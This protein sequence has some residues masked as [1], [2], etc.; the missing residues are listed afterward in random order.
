[1]MAKH[2]W[3]CFSCLSDW[4][5]AQDNFVTRP[6]QSLGLLCIQW[7]INYLT[8]LLYLLTLVHS[9]K[10]EQMEVN[11]ICYNVVEHFNPER[12]KKCIIDNNKKYGDI[13]GV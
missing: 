2:F 3:Q 12:K 13:N 11:R 4:A 5:E 6:R 9:V 1:M 7:V 8:K 10:L